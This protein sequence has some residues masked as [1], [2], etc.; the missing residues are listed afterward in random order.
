MASLAV[1]GQS[2]RRSQRLRGAKPEFEPFEDPERTP[3]KHIV[4]GALSNVTKEVKNLGVPDKVKRTDSSSSGNTKFNYI[5]NRDANFLR[6]PYVNHFCQSQDEMKVESNCVS[7]RST[8][9]SQKKGNN[10][11]SNSDNSSSKLF[12]PISCSV[13]ALLAL[14]SFYISIILPNLK[15]TTNLQEKF[16]Q[17]T[18]ELWGFVS[19]GMTSDEPFVLLLVHANKENLATTLAKDIAKL[20]ASERSKK[21][22]DASV[23]DGKDVH[24][25]TFVQLRHKFKVGIPLV[26]LHVENMTADAAEFLHFVLDVHEPWVPGGVYVLTLNLPNIDKNKKNSLNAVQHLLRKKWSGLIKEDGLEALI[27]RI[28]NFEYLV[29]T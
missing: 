1:D 25:D 16:P 8:P 18:E 12:I 6:K 22:V 21:S 13:I 24:R 28:C 26:I 15:H 23:V 27:A 4:S 3:K 20:V 10:I 2:I 9:L 19:H 17:Q 5:I 11:P 29:K 7:V 14:G